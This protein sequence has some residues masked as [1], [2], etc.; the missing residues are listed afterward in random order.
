M[1]APATALL[2]GC[3]LVGSAFFAAGVGRQAGDLHPT[4][5]VALSLT[6]LGFAALACASAGV[7]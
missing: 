7:L 1:T 6:S 5:G 3:M 4:V 2:V